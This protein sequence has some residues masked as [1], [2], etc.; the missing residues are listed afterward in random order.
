MTRVCF[1][2]QF[3][4]DSAEKVRMIGIYLLVVPVLLLLWRAFGPAS[5]QPHWA[6]SFL[7]ILAFV[8]AAAVLLDVDPDGS[9]QTPKLWTLV[10]SGAGLLVGTMIQV[11]ISLR[12][13][14][15]Q[16]QQQRSAT[17][18]EARGTLVELRPL[19]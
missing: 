4:F 16:Q 18:Q 12:R 10:G 11:L 5:V 19:S 7:W 2:V 9:L 14:L 13:R 17:K 3:G 1:D 8:A 6:P 15:Q